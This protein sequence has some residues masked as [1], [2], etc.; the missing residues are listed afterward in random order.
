ME[1]NRPKFNVDIDQERIR[2]IVS[3]SVRI[4]NEYFSKDDPLLDAESVMGSLEKILKTG[5]IATNFYLDLPNKEYSDLI[6]KV[7]PRRRRA[8]CKSRKFKKK[9]AKINH[10]IKVL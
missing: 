4:I 10:F 8:I 7:D 5:R 2:E 3:E 1:T 6:L 9:V